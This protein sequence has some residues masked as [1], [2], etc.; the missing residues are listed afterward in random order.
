[1]NGIATISKK[2]N[3]PPMSLQCP[4]VG[5][6]GDIAMKEVWKDIEGNEGLYQVSNHVR[7]RS[8]E[9]TV[10]Y[11]KNFNGSIREGL[12]SIKGKMLKPCFGGKYL[13][14]A[15]CK[16]GKRRN[17]LIHR[18]IAM[19]FIDNPENKPCVNHIDGDKLNNNIENLEWCTAQ[20]NVQHAY[21]TGL[22]KTKLNLDQAS[23]IL[24]I[25][26]GDNNVSQE[27]IAERYNIDKSLVSLIKTRK[28]WRHI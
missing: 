14:V 25:L 7:V 5:L 10:T 4:W 20:E 23:E 28:L 3:C 27:K 11:D 8:L 2:I 19:A 21:K 16:N 9:R 1:M 6:K 24:N 13:Y 26:N 17:S 12:R 22:M 15:L 18:L